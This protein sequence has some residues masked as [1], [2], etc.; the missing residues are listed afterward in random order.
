MR[1]FTAMFKR[2]GEWWLGWVEEVG[3]AFAQERTL[4]E[5]RESLA[6]A[7]RDVLELRREDA[8]KRHEGALRET[9]RIDA[10]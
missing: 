4:E 2:D 6:E 10:A 8:G 1:E 3:G 7:L 5:A 9:I